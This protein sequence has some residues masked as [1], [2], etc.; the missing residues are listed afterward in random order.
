MAINK[1]KPLLALLLAT[2]FSASGLI[3]SS[4]IAGLIITVLSIVIGL[5]LHYSAN[6]DFLYIYAIIIQP[7]IIFWST[8]IVK[9]RNGLID[10]NKELPNTLEI[11]QISNAL[12][13]GLAVLIITVGLAALLSIFNENNPLSTNAGYFLLA[14][15]IISFLISILIINSKSLESP[16]EETLLIKYLIKEAILLE[17]P[18]EKTLLNKSLK[19]EA[20]PLE[21][22]TEKT[23]N[24]SSSINFL[25][26]EFSEK[27]DY[28]SPLTYWG[29]AVSDSKLVFFLASIE[30]MGSAGIIR[31][32]IGLTAS[33]K[34]YKNRRRME[35]TLIGTD[36]EELIT[37]E[38][39]K[40]V[41][42]RENGKPIKF[43]LIKKTLVYL[44]PL[45]N[46][47]K[48]LGYDPKIRI[49]FNYIEKLKQAIP[50]LEFEYREK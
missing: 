38:K 20:I 11:E 5:A 43:L 22:P 18:T 17:S 10:N 34:N 27:K 12:G 4:W 42:N 30:P 7:F 44:L 1:K 31:S 13:W 46:D 47:K 6:P 19:K 29:L 36:I 28:F 26:A 16:T 24:K 21:S 32:I 35:K 15:I 50:E 41:Y 37:K 39:T 48:P 33:V 9:K 49:P 3:Y 2:F 25:K 14:E 8:L 45:E 23:F 40:Y